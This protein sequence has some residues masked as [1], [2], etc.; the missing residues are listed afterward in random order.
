MTSMVFILPLPA[1]NCDC[2]SLLWGPL[3]SPFGE[4]LQQVAI[5]G[6]LHNILLERNGRAFRNREGFLGG[7]LEIT[8]I[9]S[10]NSLQITSQIKKQ[11]FR[12]KPPI[13]CAQ[14][15]KHPK[16]ETKKLVK[17]HWYEQIFWK[18]MYIMKNRHSQ[19]G[20]YI[21]FEKPFRKLER[22]PRIKGSIF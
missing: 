7:S 16:L 22:S 3:S 17:L 2:C 5:F 13:E 11:K 8:D 19:K 4:G 20:K 21:S 12:N 6:V 15:F 1:L 18:A 9:H 10:K 14:Q